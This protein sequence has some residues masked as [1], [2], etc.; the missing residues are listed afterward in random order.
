M[1]ALILFAVHPIGPARGPGGLLVIRVLVVS[2]VRLC[3]EGIAVYLA[4]VEC[5]APAI[6]T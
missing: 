6:R 4:G 1:E 5:P 2:E 3:R